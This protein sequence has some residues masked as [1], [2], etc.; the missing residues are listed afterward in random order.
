M[1][2]GINTQDGTIHTLSIY[3]TISYYRFS[4]LQSPGTPP[5]V[6]PLYP[7]IYIYIYIIYIYIL[8]QVYTYT[9]VYVCFW[10]VCLHGWMDG[11]VDGWVGGRLQNVVKP[12]TQVVP[13]LVS[14]LGG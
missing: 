1:G 13:Y 14:L 11:L 9:Y 12:Q 7:Y 10:F 3:L 4:R 5:P 2:G 8:I 6:I